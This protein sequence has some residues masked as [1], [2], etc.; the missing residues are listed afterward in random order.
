MIIHFANHRFSF[1]TREDA[2]FARRRAEKAPTPSAQVDAMMETGALLSDTM[3]ALLGIV[4]GIVV[5]RIY[6]ANAETAALSAMTFPKNVVAVI[7]TTDGRW[8]VQAGTV[9]KVRQ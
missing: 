9:M 5:R 2:E 3:V 7:V 6:C 4:E 8:L 1:R